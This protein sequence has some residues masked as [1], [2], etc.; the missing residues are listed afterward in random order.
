MSKS[1]KNKKQKKK[2]LKQKAEM[3]ASQ[4][5][6]VDDYVMIAENLA[7][8]RFIHRAKDRVGDWDSPL[9]VYIKNRNPD[10]SPAKNE[11]TPYLIETPTRRWVDR[12]ESKP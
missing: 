1:K 2:R 9:I 10:D 11:A 6:I 3:S 8:S 4:M 12:R 5:A 7:K